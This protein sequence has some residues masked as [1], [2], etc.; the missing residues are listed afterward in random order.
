MP[1]SLHLPDLDDELLLRLEQRAARHGRS[2]EAEVRAI[3]DQALAAPGEQNWKDLAAEL[4]QMTVGR[5]HT[6]AEA[7]IRQDRDEH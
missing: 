2:A 6:P 7:L 4:R 1:R 3:L 5:R